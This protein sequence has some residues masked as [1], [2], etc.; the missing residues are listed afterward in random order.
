[1]PKLRLF[2]ERQ[3]AFDVQME[4]LMD[5]NQLELEQIDEV[6]IP[7]FEQSNRYATK[8]FQT[9]LEIFKL[10]T[11]L[12]D[13]RVAAKFIGEDGFFYLTGPESELD[14]AKSKL[15]DFIKKK[16]QEKFI[17]TKIVDRSLLSA[18]R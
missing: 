11:D 4:Q 9:D 3:I 12:E 16:H 8:L 6:D 18:I 15:E 10:L 2:E 17:L 5:F 7:L 13:K 14:A 1:M